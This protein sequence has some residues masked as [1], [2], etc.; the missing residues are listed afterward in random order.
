MLLGE[1]PKM[2]VQNFIDGSSKHL[3]V[4]ILKKINGANYVGGDDSALV[5]IILNPENSLVLIW[6]SVECCASW[7]NVEHLCQLGKHRMLVPIR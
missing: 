1:A 4:K 3:K 7:V 5:H 6:V 2:S